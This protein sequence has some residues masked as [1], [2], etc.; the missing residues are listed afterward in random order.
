METVTK[1]RILEVMTP[2]SAYQ[3][4]AT[5][6]SYSDGGYRLQVGQSYSVK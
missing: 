6:A 4:N 1:E 5:K 2:Y 3:I